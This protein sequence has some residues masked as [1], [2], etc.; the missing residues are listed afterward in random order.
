MY[1]KKGSFIHSFHNSLTTHSGTISAT[2]PST[3]Q[4]S[5]PLMSTT[6]HHPYITTPQSHV[7]V[8]WGT[9]ITL[10]CFGHNVHSMNAVQRHTQGVRILVHFL[11][12]FF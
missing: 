11:Q 12:M 8:R 6:D 10:S 1:I 9:P 5:T 2:V 4:S 7:T 3:T